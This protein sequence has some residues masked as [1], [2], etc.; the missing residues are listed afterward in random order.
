MRFKWGPKWMTSLLGQQELLC[1]PLSI[2]L[3]IKGYRTF[4]H[5]LDLQ[6]IGKS[7]NSYY[8]K[9]KI[10]K[11]TCILHPNSKRTQSKAKILSYLYNLQSTNSTNFNNTLCNICR[12]TNMLLL[13]RPHW[14]KTEEQA[15]KRKGE[16]CTLCTVPSRYTHVRFTLFRLCTSWKNK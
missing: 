6:N 8:T 16:R 12:T 2:D 1:S 7:Q 13:N 14:E 10:I 5:T 3:L 4:L 15:Q 9:I 11:K